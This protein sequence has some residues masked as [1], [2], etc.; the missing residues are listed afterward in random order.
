MPKSLLVVTISVK[1]ALA[2]AAT[3][4]TMVGVLVGFSCAVGRV[5]ST[6]FAQDERSSSRP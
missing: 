6:R 3:A 1:A 2:R 4:S 5:R